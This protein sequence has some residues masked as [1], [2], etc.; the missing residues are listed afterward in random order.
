M[1]QIFPRDQ[2]V[3]DIN[4]E[5]SVTVTDDIFIN[6]GSDLRYKRLSNINI[7]V[8]GIRIRSHINIYITLTSIL[9]AQ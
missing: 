1:T 6:Y 7:F 2:K 3:I 4:S 5:D 9:K 8:L